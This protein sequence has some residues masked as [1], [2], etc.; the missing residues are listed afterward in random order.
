MNDDD[1]E[2]PEAHPVVQRVYDQQAE[3]MVCLRCRVV[4]YVVGIPALAYLGSLIC[5]VF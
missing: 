2:A 1:Y 4:M 5:P 3:K